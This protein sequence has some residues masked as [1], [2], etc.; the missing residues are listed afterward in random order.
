MIRNCRICWII[1]AV[2]F[3]ANVALL[4]LWWLKSEKRGDYRKQRE[5]Y[6]EKASSRLR[7]HFK[8]ELEMNDAQFDLF[9][10]MRQE[11]MEQVYLHQIQIDSLSKLLKNQ[12]FSDIHN[13]E[14]V[15]TYA[16]ELAE[17]H[18]QLELLNYS[19]YKELRAKCS[20]DQQRERMD[21][22]FRHLIEYKH[23]RHRRGRG[24]QR[25]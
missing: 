4:S 13:Q 23:K 14:L 25:K 8:K 18:K 7:D 3:I 10:A 20:N 17:L 9:N 22:V 5:S 12:T 16:S 1:L 21:R 15:N 2:F 19:H 24:S 6:R 11:H